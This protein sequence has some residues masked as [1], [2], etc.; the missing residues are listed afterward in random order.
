MSRSLGFEEFSAWWIIWHGMFYIPKAQYGA[1]VIC[2][3]WKLRALG[4]DN[5]CL[6]ELSEIEKSVAP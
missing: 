5:L 3:L 2:T 6:I 1:G 4:V